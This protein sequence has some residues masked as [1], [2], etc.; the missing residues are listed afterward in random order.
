MSHS[1]RWKE[2]SY[3]KNCWLYDASQRSNEWLAVRKGR[4]SG[5]VAGACLGLSKFETDKAKIGREIAGLQTKSF[6][7]EQNEVVQYGIDNEE[8][9]RQ[10]YM[11]HR[12]VNVEELGFVIPKWEPRIGTS[13]DGIIDDGRGIIEIKCP[14]KMY[15]KLAGRIRCQ[16]QL[17]RFGITESSSSS[18][19]SSTNQYDHIWQTHYCQMQIS[20][21]VLERQYCD[22]IVYCPLENQVYLESIPFNREYWT[23]FMLPGLRRFHDEYIKT[24]NIEMVQPPISS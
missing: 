18:P 7:P 22:Y 12:G 20:M 2:L 5:S 24:L 21:A 16:E 1:D 4:I 3:N 23:N 10:W 17:K 19:L 8:S 6:T 13:V 14:K 15:Y 9:A 11:K